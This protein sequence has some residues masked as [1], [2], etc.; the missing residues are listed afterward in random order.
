MPFGFWRPPAEPE[1]RTS[2]RHAYEAL[3]NLLD[4]NSLL[5]EHMAE[6]ESDLRFTAPESPP[7]RRKVS[8]LAD[9]VL[10]LVEDLHLLARGQYESL[11]EAY[12]R[13]RAA[14]TRHLREAECPISPLPWTVPLENVPAVTRNLAGEK[15]SRLAQVSLV[16]PGAV[17]P[18][19]V[20]TTVSYWEFLHAG[21]LWA[22]IIPMLKELEVVRDPDLFAARLETLRGKIRA[23][24]VPEPL[25]D[26][27]LRQASLRSAPLGWAVRSSACGEDGQFSFAGQFTTLLNVPREQL[28]VAYRQVI[29]SRFESRAVA[30]RGALHLDEIDTPMAV[31]FLAMV[32]AKS[33]GVAYTR[34]P[35]DPGANR[36]WIQSVWGLAEGLVGGRMSADRFVLPRTGGPRILEKQ[37]AAKVARIERAFPAGT[38]LEPVPE[39][40]ASQPSLTLKECA[41]IRDAANR[42]EDYFQTP[43][44]I[45]WVI[46]LDGRLWVVQAR[47]LVLGQQPIE[48][49]AGVTKEPKPLLEGGTTIQPGKACGAVVCLDGGRLPTKV[50]EGSILVLPAAAPEISVLLP[51]L[52]GCI[53]EAGN[54]AGHA[55]TLLRESKIPSL[56]DA[57]GALAVL[58]NKVHVSLDA[59]NRKIYEGILW[60]Q[61]IRKR[62]QEIEDQTR[63]A[64]ILKTTVFSLNLTDPGS[65]R[66]HPSGCAS[67]HDLIRFVHEKAVETQF[68]IGDAQSRRGSRRGRRLQSDIPIPI[69]VLDLGGSLDPALEQKK[70]IEP[71]EIRSVPFQALWR[72]VTDP[73]VSWTGRRE[74]SVRGFA[75]V[76]VATVGTG[77]TG[78]GLGEQNYLLVAPDY[79]NLNLRLAY[80]YAMV[81]ALV[82]ESPDNNFINFRF[83]GGGSRADRR[84]LRARFLSE[85][86]V[87]SQFC[88]DRRGDLVTAWL[89]RYPKP[90]CEEALAL[91]GRLM[92]CSRQMDMLIGDI[93]T[94]YEYAERFLSGQYEWFG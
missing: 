48:T 45:E 12:S 25:R 18:G 40:F 49:S 82:G 35:A 84:E 36:M 13:I 75:S 1:S 73:R 63:E 11:L 30:Y 38:R 47:P 83:R 64:G 43:L 92:A 54:P 50:P 58:R 20:A 8:R 59:T 41:C 26:E 57:A 21:G 31:L 85:V 6:L 2:V 5:L 78:R 66:F 34:D 69:V 10:L 7:I 90:R 14:L 79:L 16:L 32:P 53:A 88:T 15:A 17:P 23:A 4:R 51:N 22:K 67:L 19:F 81:D 52:A 24:P 29:Q 55:A 27:I 33:A 56:F 91:L 76:L 62:P 86:L 80:H 46:D 65:P 94:A 89:R 28:D 77:G 60:P 42:L 61:D 93:R 70:A 9:E 71:S 87:R 74:V 39:E 44:D 37:I 3:R 72:G 68:E